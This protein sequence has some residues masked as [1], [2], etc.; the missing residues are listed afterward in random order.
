MSIEPFV[1]LSEQ[2]VQSLKSYLW[3][4][5]EDPLVCISCE[6]R[7]DK[8][9]EGFVN[10]IFY[11]SYGA[12]YFFRHSMFGSVELVA[13]IPLLKCEG[14]IF[15]QEKFIILNPS[16]NHQITVQTPETQ[17]IMKAIISAYVEIT[18]KIKNPPR[19][20]MKSQTKIPT[21]LIKM[22]PKQLILIRTIA[23]S[24]YFHE[25]S[26]SYLTYKYIERSQEMKKDTITI[27][28]TFKWGS[29]PQTLATVI[30]W[31]SKLETVVFQANAHRHFDKFLSTLL[32]T[33]SKIS[34]I[35]FADYKETSLPKFDFTGIKP[36]SVN[37]FYFLRSCAKLINNFLIESSEYPVPFEELSISICS[38]RPQDFGEIVTNISL[39]VPALHVKK[40][41][42]N[43]VNMKPFPFDDIQRLFSFTRDL[44]SVVFRGLIDIDASY[45]LRC[46]FEAK[47]TVR[48]MSIRAAIFR[49]LFPETLECPPSLL[50]LNISQC[51]LTGQ[52]FRSLL[53]LLTAKLLPI[54]IFF[55]AQSLV[56]KDDI[57]TCLNEMDFSKVY[58]N[59]CEFDMSGNGIA[60][61]S[62]KYLFAFLYTQ[63]RLHMVCF[64]DSYSDQPIKF[65][66]NLSTLITE[67]NLCGFEISG[68][69]PDAVL[70]HFILTLAKA[71]ELRHIRIQGK[72]PCEYAL[73]ATQTLIGSLPNLVE[74]GIDSFQPRTPQPFFDLW[75]SIQQKETIKAIEIPINDINQLGLSIVALDPEKK[76][77]FDD[78]RAK[79]KISVQL[80][81]LQ[82]L[83]DKPETIV[84][85]PI[86]NIDFESNDIDE[87]MLKYV[88]RK[89]FEECSQMS[90]WTDKAEE[91]KGDIDNSE[92]KD[93]QQRPKSA[94]PQ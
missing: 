80:K 73:C 57:Y 94:T 81:R 22:R 17:K 71:N 2:K 8:E 49:T 40:L 37:R 46:L 90:S 51:Q 52:V 31:E 24:H 19:L 32:S 79:P 56:M 72:L 14:L 15:K 54:P 86:D 42:I 30:G 69:Y 47:S 78:L 59:L 91:E 58:P 48:H 75:K 85:L 83:I 28:P 41:I 6:I 53:E 16:T 23:L 89:I 67:R 3:Y 33:T 64:N 70:S 36:T 9:K 66:N 50:A 27:G 29:M 1:N 12:L 39:S 13:D 65:L 44:E 25:R 7:F 82:C 18:F 5:V 63:S 76:Q 61:A 34:K 55:T 4:P 45:L 62:M 26:E 84:K 38:M 35:I 10:G 87:I 11:L 92:K 68:K 74:I 21:K 43:R 20:K 93:I 60:D 77:V 88:N